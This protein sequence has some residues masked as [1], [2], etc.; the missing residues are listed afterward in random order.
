M[1]KAVIFDKDGVIVETR[2]LHFEKWKKTF[3]KYNK[4]FNEKILN[5]LMGR[6][7]LALATSSR[8]ESMN[9]VLDKFKLRSYFKVLVNAYDVKSA[10]PDPEIYLSTAKKLKVKPND[11]AVFED[12]YSG[13]EAAKRAGMKIIL[14]MTSLTQKEIPNAN[15]AIKDFIKINVADVK[16]I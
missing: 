10:K 8:L 1:A 15:L 3:E 12:S 14:V 4:S 11:C 13:V 2:K 16:M 9:L 7:P 5:E 6:I